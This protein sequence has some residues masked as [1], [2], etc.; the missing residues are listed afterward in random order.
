MPQNKIQQIPY[1]EAVEPF[2][3]CV[4]LEQSLNVATIE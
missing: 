4:L 1:L 3:L 2:F